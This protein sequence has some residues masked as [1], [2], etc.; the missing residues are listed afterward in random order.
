[1]EKERLRHLLKAY[2]TGTITKHDLTILLDYIAIPQNEPM[3]DQLLAELMEETEEDTAL[4]LASDQLYQRITAHSQFHPQPVKASRH[5]YRWVSAAAAL[6]MIAGGLWWYF[7]SPVNNT[8]PDKEQLI[9][10]VTSTP[11]ER[12]LLKTS[13]GQIIDLDNSGNN[14]ETGIAAL[15]FSDDGGLTYN[16][17][18][19]I[20]LTEK[21]TIM[22]PKG[23]RYHITLSD[24][25]KVWLNSATTMTF[26]ARF[27]GDLRE[28]ELDGEAY[29]EVKRAENWPFVVQTNQQKIQ[30]LGTHFNVN[31]YR[32]DQIT[33]T[34]LLEGKVNV[35]TA[36]RNTILRPGKQAKTTGKS[37]ALEVKSIEAKDILAW[38]ENMFVFNNEEIQQVMRQVS[39]WYDVEVVYL[40]GMEGKRIEG[41]IPRL[42]SIQELMEALQA[43]GLLHY[44]MKGGQIIIE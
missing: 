5:Y 1:M 21:H 29:F 35:A 12:L 13:S 25:T 20:A 41:S 38:K 37:D 9:S 27:Q 30:V 39:R 28:I 14:K 17:D 26:P 4:P 23:R 22:T 24:G 32:E 10:T 43:T 18:E 44:Q 36:T 11:T 6:L 16:K 15:H 19:N 3:I 34:S 7:R 8:V 33:Y 2:Q 31:A 40:D 42:E